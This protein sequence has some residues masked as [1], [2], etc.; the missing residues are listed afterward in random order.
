MNKIKCELLN[1]ENKEFKRIKRILNFLVSSRPRIDPDRAIIYTKIFKENPSKPLIIKRALALQELLRS[2]K[3]TIYDDELIV[4]NF[5][6][7]PRSAYVFPEYSVDFLIDELNGKPFTFDKR[8][9]DRFEIDNETTETLKEI[10]SWWKGQTNHDYIKELIQEETQEAINS[11]VINIDWLYVGGQGHLTPNFYYVLRNGLK[12]YEKRVSRML[13]D[14]SVESVEQINFLKAAKIIIEAIKEYAERFSKLADDMAK[15]EKDENRKKE[16]KRI[17]GICSNVPFNPARDLQEALQSIYFIQSILQMEDSGHSM[18]LGRLDQNLYDYYLIEKNKNTPLTEI[19]ELLGCFWL[20]LFDINKLR[21]WE[22]TMYFSGYPMFQNI[23]IGG[24]KGYGIDATNELS[25][26]ILLVQS[27]IRL[28]APSIS[29]RYHDNIDD[30]FMDLALDVINLGGGQ[31][32]IYSDE[33]FLPSLLLRGYDLE[34]ALNYSMVGCVEPICEGRAGYRPN[35]SGFFNM[36]KVLEIT[37]FD[38]KDVKT[39]KVLHKNEKPVD[40][41]RDFDE[42]SDELKKQYKYFLHQHVLLDNTVNDAFAHNVPNILVSILIDDCVDRAQ[43][44]D[45]GG[46]VYDMMGDQMLGLANLGNSL[47]SIKK[48]IFDEKNFTFKELKEAILSDFECENGEKIKKLCQSAPK[49]GNDIDYVDYLT[50]DIFEFICNEY[51]T[52][53]T[54]R[55]NKGPKICRWVPSTS[56]ITGNVPFGTYIMASPDGRLSGKPLSDGISAYMGSDTQ[57]PT[58]VIKSVGK[59]NNLLVT[60]GQLFNLKIDPMIFKNKKE[61]IKNLIETYAGDYKGMHIQFNILDDKVLIDA[62]KNPEK[63]PNL[64]VR[65]AG[66]SALFTALNPDVQDMIIERTMHL[67]Q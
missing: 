4:G 39:G 55:Y 27:L 52:Y 49:Y 59:L 2:K 30:K 38:G 15:S 34:D 33:V 53:H 50:R 41:I 43:T 3:I 31:P 8:P 19:Y 57:G 44:I 48:N 64:M 45:D 65:V 35:G 40:E 56:T 9:G 51:T 47:A 58:A 28:P 1:I 29:L 17:S 12:G 5:C 25:Y 7:S 42:F 11:G 63:Y 36:P 16:L 18:S 14:N 23:T 10:C 61:A 37:M 20:K 22:S 67:M 60:G 21:S 46:A 13:S 24:Q 66:Y 32:A 6:A 26:I 54:T 62:K